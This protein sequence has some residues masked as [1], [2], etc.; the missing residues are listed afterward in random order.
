MRKVTL[1]D[2]AKALGVSK[3]LV[4]LVLNGRGDEHGINAETQQRVR[5]KAK[6][7]NY[8]PN[9]IARGLRTGKSNTIG[10]IVTDISNI[11]MAKMA[12]AIEDKVRASNYNMVFCSSDE[13]PER[14]ASLIEMLRERQVDGI[15]L[16]TSAKDNSRI[17]ELHKEGYPLV[18]ID[19]SLENI[20]TNYVG[21]NN[22]E[23]ARDAVLHLINE[24]F[25]KIGL[26][27]ITPKYISP[28]RDRELGYKEALKLK[29]YPLE[30]ELIRDIPFDNIKEMVFRELDDLCYPQKKI[31]AIF[32]ANNS[33]AIACLQ[34]FKARDLSIPE[35]VALI[36][37]DDI[38][39]FQFSNPPISAVAQPIQAI[40][41]QA[42]ALLMDRLKNPKGFENQQ[43][44]IETE[45]LIRTSSQKNP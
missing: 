7:L 30:E 20:S 42:V 44:E 27:A 18:L 23:G 31:D 14:E 19:R 38:E 10:L 17:E 12:R 36:S 34:Y 22:F 9:P 43:V 35:D 21:A 16:M 41:E 32:A 4:S 8:R 15:I 5:K 2:I 37:F 1:A 25:Q 29:N 40:G 45:L 33:I 24:G 3:T 11:F 6:E 28:I 26:L 39:L 13:D